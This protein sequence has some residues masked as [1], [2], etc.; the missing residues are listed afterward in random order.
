MYLNLDELML[1]VHSLNM[2][3]RQYLVEMYTAFLL[4]SD[5]DAED[6]LLKKNRVKVDITRN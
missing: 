1:K 4:R 5:T 3:A 6:A 2:L